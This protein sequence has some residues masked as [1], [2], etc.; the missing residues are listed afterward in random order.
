MPGPRIK[1]AELLVENL[2]ELGE[3][4][5]RVAVVDGNVVA[6]AMAQR[7]SDPLSRTMASWPTLVASSARSF[8]RAARTS[9]V[10]CVK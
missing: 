8:S 6:G 7:G 2:I 10:T 5:I 9:P 1:I 4:L 3:E